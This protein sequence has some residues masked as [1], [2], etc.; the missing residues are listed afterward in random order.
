MQWLSRREFR[1]SPALLYAS[2][3]AIDIRPF[4]T[5]YKYGKLVLSA[6]AGSREFDSKFVDCP[7]VFHL[8]G[9][10]Y[11]TY[12]G[13]D[14]NGY[15]TELAS[16]NDLTNWKK[17]GC[18]FR[19]DSESRFLRYNAA[20]NW[21]VRENAMRSAGELKRIRGRFLGAY[22]AYPGPGLEEGPTAIGLCWVGDG[23]LAWRDAVLLDG[24]D[25]DAGNQNLD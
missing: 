12:V 23:N 13:Y 25:V 11:Q 4:R 2:G 21:I 10:F 24:V 9:R 8:E 14:G 16:S 20:L 3:E 18:I 5:P 6:S 19:R 7:F 1:G 22:R 15:Q 17:L